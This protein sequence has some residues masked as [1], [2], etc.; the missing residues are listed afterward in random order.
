MENYL[1]AFAWAEWWI[2]LALL[3]LKENSP[4]YEENIYPTWNTLTWKNIV[5]GKNPLDIWLYNPR[6][7]VLLSYK[8]SANSNSVN[9]TKIWT[10]EYAIYPLFSASDNQGWVIKVTDISFLPAWDTTDVSDI[11]WNIV[12]VESWISWKWAISDWSVI[13]NYKTSN[14]FGEFEFEYKTITD[15]LNSSEDNY[16]VLFNSSSNTSITYSVNL[17]NPSEY[18]IKN[19]VEIFATWEL[20]K[21]RQNLSVFIDNSRYLNLLKYAIYNK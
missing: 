12:W 5:L 2:E 19:H 3:K 21:Y 18:F 4:V 14:S 8:I 7:D 1:K 10:W 11:V 16:L 6:R 13:W 9:S 17:P 15:F 20:W